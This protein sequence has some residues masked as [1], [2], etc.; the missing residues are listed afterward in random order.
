M[1]SSIESDSKEMVFKKES[2]IMKK[3]ADG[4][5]DNKKELEER[6]K[7]EERREEKK[8]KNYYSSILL[9]T[10]LLLSHH[11]SCLIDPRIH[12]SKRN[13]IG[14][15]S[16]S[17]YFFSP[18]ALSRLLFILTSFSFNLFPSFLV[19]LNTPLIS[20]IFS[21]S[22]ISLRIPSLSFLSPPYASPSHS[23][24]LDPS[25]PTFLSLNLSPIIFVL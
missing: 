17:S 10:F 2:E 12:R 5:K 6:K 19:P 14:R 22:D 9:F 16:T 23:C 24:A 25:L 11:P 13:H 20:S 4:S 15:L 21:S 3:E 1:K 8:S 7:R 18:R